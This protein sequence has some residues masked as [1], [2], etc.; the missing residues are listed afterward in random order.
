[1]PNRGWLIQQVFK[2]LA[3]LPLR[4]CHALA[5][6]LGMLLYGL[7]NRQRRV[8]ATNLRLCFPE[9]SDAQRRHLLRRTLVENAKTLLE[10]PGIWLGD[11]QVWLGRIEDPDAGCRARHLLARGY[12]LIIA[13]PHLGSWEAGIHYLAS[14][15]P[16][17]ALYRPPREGSLTEWMLAGRLRSGTRLVPTT[18][19]GVKALYEG[20]RR[21]EMVTILPDQQ[22]AVREGGGVFAPFFGVPALTMTMLGRLARKTGAP[23]IFCFAERLPGGRGYRIHWVEAPVGVD[24]ADPVRA[25]TA[26]NLGVEAC[27]RLC[28]EQYQWLYKR[29]KTRPQGLPKVYE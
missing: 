5:G 19:A 13:A 26:L 22:P 7:P 2:L 4:G 9:W 1:V 12:G 18:V 24:D 16:I 23:L 27:A 14:L 10:T 6:A 11:S 15:A 28:P 29:F 25:A 3:R 20:L 8:A 17:T 21:G